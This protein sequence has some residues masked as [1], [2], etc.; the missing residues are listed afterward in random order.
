M[1]AAVCE[2]GPGDVCSADPCH[3]TP[4]ERAKVRDLEHEAWC[5][6]FVGS[7]SCNCGAVLNDVRGNAGDA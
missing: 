6:I 5:A 1:S 2:C 3:G 7:I 4:P